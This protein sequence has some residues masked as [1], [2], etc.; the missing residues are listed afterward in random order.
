MALV[1]SRN[2]GAGALS[3]NMSVCVEGQ[4]GPEREVSGWEEDCWGGEV[5]I[6]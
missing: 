5:G 4:G 6:I 2:W 3:F 1:P